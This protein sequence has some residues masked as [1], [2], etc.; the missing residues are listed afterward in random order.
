[1]SRITSSDRSST[2][3]DLQFLDSVYQKISQLSLS[4]EEMTKVK[5]SFEDPLIAK[6]LNTTFED[7]LIARKFVESFEVPVFRKEFFEDP[8]IAAEKLNR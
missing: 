8:L 2:N 4:R 1:M 6:K 7:P 5:T 3:K